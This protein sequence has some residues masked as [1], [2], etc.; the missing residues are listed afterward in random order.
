MIWVEIIF[1]PAMLIL[2]FGYIVP[3]RNTFTIIAFGIVLA[4]LLIPFL[5]ARKRLKF[6]SPSL[7]MN[8]EFLAFDT[9][10][11][12][13]EDI[14]SGKMISGIFGDELEIIDNK[15]AVHRISLANLNKSAWQIYVLA[16]KFFSMK[17]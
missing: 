2:Y 13:W 7:K 4:L 5:N 15:A 17:N 8:S 9:Y 3:F 6:H 16:C 10:Q 12:R 1:F 11:I 14:S